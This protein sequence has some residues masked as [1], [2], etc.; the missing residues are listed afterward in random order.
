[1]KKYSLHADWLDY[2]NVKYHRAIYVKIG[3]V[4]DK[5]TK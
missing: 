2:E 4:L 5:S 1:M 3:H